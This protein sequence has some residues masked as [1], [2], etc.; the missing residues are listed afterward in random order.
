M[1]AVHKRY[2][3]ELFLAMAAYVLF[4][5]FAKWALHHIDNLPLRAFVAIL[6]VLPVVLA[7]LA[8]FRVILG[9]DELER[10]I[11]LES[12][13]LGAAIT[14]AGFL[15]YGL[16]LNADVIPHADADAVA[17]WVFP[18]LMVGFGLVKCLIVARR[19]RGDGE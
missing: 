11:D 4:I 10:R 1:R 7:L 9:Q 12:I 5:F 19:Y 15:G 18:A 16:L 3:R 8:I 13:A 17:L 14:G 2:L 6:P